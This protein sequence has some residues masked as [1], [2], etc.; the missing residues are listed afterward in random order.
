VEHNG[1]EIG[2]VSIIRKE[3]GLIPF[4]LDSLGQSSLCNWNQYVLLRISDDEQ[5]QEFSNPKCSCY[6]Q[7]FLDLIY[8]ICIWTFYA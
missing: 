8:T 1:L 6:C 5:V 7:N 4:S 3:Y 2:A